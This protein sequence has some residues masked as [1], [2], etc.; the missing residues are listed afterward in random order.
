MQRIGPPLEVLTRRLIETPADFLDEPRIGS[1][2]TVHVA[3]L[4]N[5]LMQRLDRRP[6]AP[7]LARFWSRDAQA[8]RNR[9]A[10]TM[11]VA[12]LLADEWFRTAGASQDALVALLDQGVGELAL[13]TPAHRFVTDP[14]RREELARIV[15]ARLDAR[16]EGE[17]IA[18]AT[19]RLSGL[20]GTERRR[21]LEASRASEQRARLIREAL[22]RKAAEESADKWT[23]E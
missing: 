12:W 21:L 13:A 14:D 16:P 3:A 7:A 15:L 1:S 22:A 11:I 6:P 9:L 5:D 2:G 10:L 17:T 20:S 18:Q 4:V 19:D 8:D 23:R